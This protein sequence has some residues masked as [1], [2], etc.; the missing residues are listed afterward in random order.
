MPHPH[1]KT[2]CDGSAGHLSEI[3]DAAWRNDERRYLYLVDHFQLKYGPVEQI[4][5]DTEDFI[6]HLQTE[7][8]QRGHVLM[9]KHL[10]DPIV[11]DRCLKGCPPS[12]ELQ[13]LQAR[14]VADIDLISAARR[15]DVEAAQLSY[16]R[17]G[18]NH[19][20]GWYSDQ[21]AVHVAAESGS[22]MILELIFEQEPSALNLRVV[23]YRERTPLQLA[24]LGGHADAVALIL[25]RDPKLEIRDHTN[26][27]AVHLAF[28]RMLTEDQWSTSIM[29]F[30]SQKTK[31]PPLDSTDL[32]IPQILSMLLDVRA[33]IDAKGADDGFTC[34]HLAC[35]HGMRSTVRYLIQRGA[36]VDCTSEYGFTPL[37]CAVLALNP[38]LVNHL[39]SLGARIDIHAKDAGTARY[40]ASIDN[41]RYT[42]ATEAEVAERKMKCYEALDAC[43]RSACAGPNELVLLVEKGETN[44]YGHPFDFCFPY[45]TGESRQALS[46]WAASSKKDE[47]GLFCAFF[48]GSGLE[49]TGDVV[50]LRLLCGP[51]ATHSGLRPIRTRVVQNLVSGRGSR[52]LAT[53]II[54]NAT[55]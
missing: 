53:E 13:F 19:R 26:R 41:D 27:T 3:I 52:D 28:E 10:R 33:N 25:R 46:I 20:P 24:I 43:E 32:Q 48:I 38:E 1:K 17:G 44:F 21:C 51:K 34:L 9:M 22:C 16:R 2:K 40:L 29:A 35:L 8:K 36:D 14:T 37:H 4:S 47:I 5:T 45:F 18:K 30:K 23:D 49:A 6:S 7:T 11:R 42:K 15:N 55:R 54:R 31:Y 39:L 50:R 12:R